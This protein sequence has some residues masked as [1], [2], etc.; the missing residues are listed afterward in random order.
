MVL[1]IIQISLADMVFIAHQNRGS[2]MRC[3]KV[4]AILVFLTSC[5]VYDAPKYQFQG[6]QEPSVE[7]VQ[8]SSEPVIVQEPELLEEY[9]VIQS[10]EQVAFLAFSSCADVKAKIANAPSGNYKLYHTNQNNEA[11]TY[12]SHC[13]LEVDNGGWT[14]VLNYVHQ[15]GTNPP[16]MIRADSLPNLNSSTLGDDEQNTEYWG[17]AAPSF[18]S[19]FNISELRFFCQSSLHNRTIHF[20]T[21]SANCIN[22]VKTGVGNCSD[23]AANFVPL[24]GHTGML[25]GLQADAQSN[26]LDLALTNRILRSA[27]GALHW[28]IAAGDGLNNHWEC[29]DDID[30]ESQHTI[31]RVWVR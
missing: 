4:F 30:N 7:N 12:D 5:S 10:Q 9:E 13:D 11:V 17:H 20:K 21:T 24:E 29:D 3:A 27:D 2:A 1:F 19:Q 25:P 26:A 28:S 14:M 6:R 18:L 16:L 31:H 15:A 22:Y 8:E 23:V